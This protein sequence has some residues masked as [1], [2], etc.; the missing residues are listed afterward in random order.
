MALNSF[1]CADVPLRNYSLTHSCLLFVSAAMKSLSTATDDD[2]C[3]TSEDVRWPSSI[4]AVVWPPWSSVAEDDESATSVD[5]RLTSRTNGSDGDDSPLELPDIT[6]N[7]AGI[8]D[9]C[10]QIMCQNSSTVLLV[11]LNISQLKGYR[12]LYCNFDCLYV[13]EKVKQI[14][15]LLLSDS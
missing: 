12:F 6:D 11:S 9:C 13:A 15:L 8:S 10:W 4:I 1:F 5:A 7:G 14:H 2:A 3:G